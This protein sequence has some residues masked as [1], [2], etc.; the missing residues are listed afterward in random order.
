MTIHRC[1]LCQK[2]DAI[3]YWE[4]TITLETT[5]NKKEFK[6]ITDVCAE[7]FE[8]FKHKGLLNE[9]RTDE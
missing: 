2:N 5:D 6:T 4:D 8:K 7:C 3:G 1:D 9:Y